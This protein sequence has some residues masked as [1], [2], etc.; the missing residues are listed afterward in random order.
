MLNST[1]I[2]F[3]KNHCDIIIVNMAYPSREQLERSYDA[4]IKLQ[5]T[6][7]RI[8][9]KAE[10]VEEKFTKRVARAAKPVM[11]PEGKEA[12]STMTKEI[13]TQRKDR[14]LEKLKTK[15]VKAVQVYDRTLK[16]N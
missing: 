14:A 13:A 4:K 11:T 15:G 7:A 1:K 6:K 9:R 3:A 16:N 8:V 2:R 10:K 5:D 12:Y